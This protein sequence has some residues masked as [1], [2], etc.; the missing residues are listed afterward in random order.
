MKITK[1]GGEQVDIADDSKVQVK[2]SGAMREV[3]MSEALEM[4]THSAGADEKFRMASDLSKTKESEIE[5]L[6]TQLAEAEQGM[7][8]IR[9][10]KEAQTDDGAFME[11]AGIMGMSEEDAEI[12]LR[13]VRGSSAVDG[14]GKKTN[15][16]GKKEAGEMKLDKENQAKLDLAY[17]GA[18]E[19][20][21]E[22]AKKEMQELL[23]K[24]EKLGMMSKEKQ[25]EL[26]ER[27][28]KPAVVSRL[29]QG[30]TYGPILLRNALNEVE[31][32]AGSLGILPSPAASAA[33]RVEK[34]TRQADV[35]LGPEERNTL[36]SAVQTGSP[37]SRKSAADDEWEEN[38]VARA[39]AEEAI[40]GGEKE[41]KA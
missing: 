11:L 3:T 32:T 24:H 13:E 36:I 23:S 29:Q 7:L 20:G 30:E 33:E 21:A 22:K 18:T 16:G 34:V 2:V 37:P 6:K 1:P 14:D 4:A 40:G 41:A 8:V 9:L 28:Y 39:L 12:K 5:A 19:Q 17:K 35:N 25:K 31:A 15:T 10:S 26:L 38:F 27:V